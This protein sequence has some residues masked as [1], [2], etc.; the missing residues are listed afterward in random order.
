MPVKQK[1]EKY[2]VGLQKSLPRNN[3]HPL[4]GKTSN[5]R[6]NNPPLRNTSQSQK[7]GPFTK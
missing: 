5:I 1:L 2:F 7:I 6:K 3:F 4:N